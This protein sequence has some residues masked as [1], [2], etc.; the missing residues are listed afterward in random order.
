MR[1]QRINAVCFQRHR[2]LMI[3][4]SIVVSVKRGWAEIYQTTNDFSFFS[5]K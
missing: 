2:S 5:K 1:V 3:F 4:K